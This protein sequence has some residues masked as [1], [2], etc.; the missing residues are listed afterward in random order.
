VRGVKPQAAPWSGHL[1][2][3]SGPAGGGHAG[4]AP[5]TRSRSLRQQCRSRLP[6]ERRGGRNPGHFVR[7]LPRLFR[8]ATGKSVL[9]PR[10]SRPG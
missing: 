5:G 3:R 6:Y 8:V 9:T 7:R 1:A 4:D 2:G 10:R